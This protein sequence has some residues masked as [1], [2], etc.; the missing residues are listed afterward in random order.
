MPTR[1]Q[2]QNGAVIT[3]NTPISVTGCAASS[4]K[5]MTKAPANHKKHKTAKK[6]VKRHG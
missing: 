4:V 5:P 6:H 2:G 3:Q 1:I